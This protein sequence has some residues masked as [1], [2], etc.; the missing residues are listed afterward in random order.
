MRCSLKLSGAVLALGSV[1]FVSCGTDPE[2]QKRK[3]FESG[4][5]YFTEK[6]YPEAIIEFRNALQQDPKFGEARLLLGDAYLQT[7]DARA[8]LREY[9]RGADI[10]A[11]NVEAQLKADAPARV[12][13]VQMPEDGPKRRWLDEKNV[14]AHIS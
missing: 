6:K 2:V 8:A 12:G 3:Y 9:A 7:Q 14:D 13:A 5:R 11:D 10:L 4:N 1:L